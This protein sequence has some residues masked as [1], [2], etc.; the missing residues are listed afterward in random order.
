MADILEEEIN[1][2]LFEN[3]NIL[4]KNYCAGKITILK[5]ELIEQ[6]F[7]FSY[8]TSRMVNQ[9]DNQKFEFNYDFGIGK[10]KK[11]CY[12]IIYLFALLNSNAST[13]Q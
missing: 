3:R 1:S 10:I 8:H 9:D 4:R 11:N 6:G 13:T 5:T 2:I 7:N 12:E